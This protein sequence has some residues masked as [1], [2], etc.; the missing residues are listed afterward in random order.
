MDDNKKPA[1]KA[2]IHRLEVRIDGLETRMDRLE[3]KV[4]KVKDALDSG[5][6]QVLTVLNNIDQRLS[7]SVKD[8]ERRIT[9]LEDHVGIAS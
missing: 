7:D 3:T 6:D 4:N 5:I 8:H 2:D 1:T 9:R